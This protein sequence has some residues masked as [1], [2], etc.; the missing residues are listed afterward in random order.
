MSWKRFVAGYLHFSK[1]DRAGVLG[2]LLLLAL[3]F[4]LPLLAPNKVEIPQPLDAATQLAT[5]S[6]KKMPANGGPSEDYRSYA[7][8]RADDAN[9][10]RPGELF[11]FDPNTLDDAGWRRL[12]LREKTIRTINNYR[13]KG[14]RFYKPQD[15]AKIWSLPPGFYDRVKGHIQIAQPAKKWEEPAYAAAPTPFVKT[16]PK[17]IDINTADTA[18]FIALP[19]IGSKLAAR[20]VNFRSKLGGFTS[21]EQLGETYGLPDSTFQKIRSRLVVESGALQAINL[22]TATKEVLSGHPYINWKLANA[23]VAYREQ[24]GAFTSVDDLKKIMI[25][26]E[27][28]FEKL[29][30]YLGL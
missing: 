11:A 6:L 10:F 23:I 1:R 16:A 29:R 12:G 5:D 26:D 13:S 17:T 24:H 4:L 28:T 8:E 21:V 2:L 22:N 15:L 18:A 7:F 30:P 9:K 20:I 27:A 14:G 25:L 19:G 3:A